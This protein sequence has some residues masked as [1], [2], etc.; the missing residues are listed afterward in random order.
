MHVETKRHT[1]SDP[2]RCTHCRCR[3]IGGTRPTSRGGADLRAREPAQSRFE[4][5]CP[6][7][8]LLAYW[9][10]GHGECSADNVLV[11]GARKPVGKGEWSERLL[12]ADSHDLP[13][14]NPVLFVDPRGKL[15]L[16]WIAVQS[17]QWGC[18]FATKQYRAAT[19]FPHYYPAMKGRPGSEA[20]SR[21]VETGR[22]YGLVPVGNASKRRLAERGLSR[23]SGASPVVGN[24]S[25]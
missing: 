17:N 1:E 10:H 6:N 22:G 5:E 8:D 23:S 11:Q 3:R 15:W 7:G 4:H 24:D 13:A 25:F 19:V 20:T 2:I 21:A 9:S 14:C 18:S 12:M 16:F